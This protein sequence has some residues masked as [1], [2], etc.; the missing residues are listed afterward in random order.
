MQR[1]ERYALCTPTTPPHKATPRRASFLPSVTLAAQSSCHLPHDCYNVSRGVKGLKHDECMNPRNFPNLAILYSHRYCTETE[2][3]T[4]QPLRQHPDDLHQRSRLPTAST[5][6]VSPSIH[7]LRCWHPACSLDGA[8]P[9][10]TP[11]LSRS[12]LVRPSHPKTDF[13]TYVSLYSTP[14]L[15]PCNKTLPF[16]DPWP[17][18]VCPTPCPTHA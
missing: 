3:A 7:P 16:S 10:G 18:C 5:L 13:V 12:S 17:I 2:F 11:Y 14:C 1:A 9:N 8:G 15:P 6:E 4:T